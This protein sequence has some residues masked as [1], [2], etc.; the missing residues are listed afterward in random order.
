MKV[1]CDCGATMKETEAMVYNCLICEMRVSILQIT[2]FEK[3]G[4]A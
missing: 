4:D 3:G 2:K 1:I